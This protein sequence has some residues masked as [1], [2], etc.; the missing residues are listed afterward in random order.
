[1]SVAMSTLFFKKS[2]QISA[3]MKVYKKSCVEFGCVFFF[4]AD[5]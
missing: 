4:L 3:E 2:N 1:M 5:V